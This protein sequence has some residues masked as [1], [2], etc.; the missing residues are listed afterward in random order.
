ME[1]TLNKTTV[2]LLPGRGFFANKK[3]Y[4]YFFLFFL[5]I[6]TKISFSQNT[7]AVN[8]VN[9]IHGRVADA[10]TQKPISGATVD[11]VCQDCGGAAKAIKAST[12]TDENGFYGFKNF[13][14]PKACLSFAL[15]AGKKNYLEDLQFSSKW[16]EENIVINFTLFSNPNKAVK[17]PLLS[18]IKAKI[19][20]G[21]KIKVPVAFQKVHLKD[22]KDVI[23]QT[24]TTDEFGDF[25]FSDVDA[26]GGHSIELSKNPA[27]KNEK[28]FLA[29]QN[30]LVIGE[31]KMNSSGA[32]GF[33]LLPSEVVTL[34]LMDEKDEPLKIMDDFLKSAKKEITIMDNI[35]YETAQWDITTSA[36]E[37]LD[38][39]VAALKENPKLKV[40]IYAHTDSRG[41]AE[42]NLALSEKRAKSAVKYIVSKG[43]DTKR[44]SGKGFGEAKI[45][46]RCTDGVNCSEDEQKLNRRTEFRFVKE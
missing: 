13:I 15:T 25:T 33:K 37:R 29:K 11:L 41:E 10:E 46:N 28:V 32:F 8:I 34:T 9:A 39:V 31:F 7:A 5:V 18:R 43:I 45:L 44:I 38:K 6:L 24:T 30:G 35:Y 1:N 26:N 4:N 2:A 21:D 17:Q 16:T 19:L 3:F 14:C 36:A 20:K 40:E 23:L 27:L 42:A 22:E 12:I